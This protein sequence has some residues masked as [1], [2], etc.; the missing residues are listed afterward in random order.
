MRIVKNQPTG[1]SLHPA[2]IWS[3]ERGDKP[4]LSVPKQDLFR[5]WF[6]A[7]FRPDFPKNSGWIKKT[8]QR[9]SP[10]GKSAL[11]IPLSGTLSEDQV[12]NMICKKITLND[13]SKL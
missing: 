7:D 3:V 9:I 8:Y 12:R 6:L 1:T 2:I 11:P 5:L 10:F 4:V 13:Y